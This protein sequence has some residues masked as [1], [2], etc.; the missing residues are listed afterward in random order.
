M[1]VNHMF[2]VTSLLKYSAD[3]YGRNAYENDDI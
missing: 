1:A 2:R 3:L